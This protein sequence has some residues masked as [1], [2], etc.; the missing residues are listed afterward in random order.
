MKPQLLLVMATVLMTVSTTANRLSYG[1]QAILPSVVM[2]VAFWYAWT[3]MER[4][5][6]FVSW[7]L[8]FTIWAVGSGVLSLIVGV[9]FFDDSVTWVQGALVSVMALCGVALFA[10]VGR[11]L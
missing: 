3:T 6:P 8:A 2:L 9:L 5:A 11:V 10:S 7:S 4:A 1:F